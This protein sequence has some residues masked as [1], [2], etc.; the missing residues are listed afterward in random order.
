MRRRT[1]GL[2]LPVVLT[3]VA[4]LLT[5]CG[6]SDGFGGATSDGTD[7]ETDAAAGTS[8]DAGGEDE[9]GDA[10]ADTD[11]EEVTIEFV[12]SFTLEAV[13]HAGFRRFQEILAEEAPWVTLEHR[14]GPETIPSQQQGEAVADGAVDMATLPANFYSGLI[15]LMHSMKLTTESPADERESGAYDLYEE[16]H[17]RE[18]LHL[19][20]R[21]SAE[22]PFRLF[23]NRELEE[24]DLSG[25]DI[26][27]SPVYVQVVQGLGG[28]PTRMDPGDVYTALERGVVDGYGWAGVGLLVHGWHEVTDYEIDIDF[29]EMDM[30]AIINH[31]VW[32]GF[33]TETQ[34]AITRATERADEAV[35]EVYGELVGEEVQA[36]RDAG[37][38]PLTF[39]EEDVNSFLEMAYER[40]WE[41]AIE[42]DS[43]AEQLREIYGL[44]GDQ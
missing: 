19:L 33:D 43:D 28:T 29:Y 5:A 36:R 37:I 12:S 17:E 21:M 42:F 18:G 3:V 4:L 31:D 14:G 30:V 34:E 13:E 44:P 2:R 9:T 40:G 22:T 32:E 25:M 10:P 39:P 8:D 15:P 38:E 6:G 11:H 24:L 20:G 26:R 16:H 7:G 35:V 1:D 27:V 41:E 23:M